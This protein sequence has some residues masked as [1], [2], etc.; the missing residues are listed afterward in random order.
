MYNNPA[1]IQDLV[2][3]NGELLIRPMCVEAVYKKNYHDGLWD[4][5][6]HLNNGNVLVTSFGDDIVNDVIHRVVGLSKDFE[7][8]I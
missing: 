6:I 3:P 1:R 2:F 7:D 5:E 4:V 8:E